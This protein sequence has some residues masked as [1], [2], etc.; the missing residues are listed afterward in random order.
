MHSRNT[1]E[2]CSWYCPGVGWKHP[3]FTKGNT[4]ST[5]GSLATLVL[6]LAA[7]FIPQVLMIHLVGGRRID[8]EEYIP[9]GR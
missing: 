7:I 9:D 8:G 2:N 3:S 6:V 1:D 4:M 5:I